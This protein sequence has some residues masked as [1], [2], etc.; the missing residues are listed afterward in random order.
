MT[1]TDRKRTKEDC[2]VCTLGKMTN[3]RAKIER[4]KAPI[5]LVHTDLVGQVT[6]ESDEGF[7]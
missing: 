1:I 2:E 3:T 6:P 4:T 5:E 7:K